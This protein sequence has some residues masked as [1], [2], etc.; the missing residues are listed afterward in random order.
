[1]QIRPLKLSTA[2][3]MITFSLGNLY[4]LPDTCVGQANLA[5]FSDVV[6]RSSLSCHLITLFWFPA[7]AS[8]IAYRK[9]ERVTNHLGDNCI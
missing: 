3:I 7:T 1:M 6:I 2:I 8:R 9:N 5:I 4:F